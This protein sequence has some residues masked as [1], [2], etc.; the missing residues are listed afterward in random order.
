[1]I[2]GY[3]PRQFW[4]F[5]FKKGFRKGNIGILIIWI[6]SSENLNFECYKSILLVDTA[7]FWYPYAM[8][9]D[10]LYCMTF[11]IICHKMAFITD[12]IWHKVLWTIAMWVSN[13]HL[14][15]YSRFIAFKIIFDLYFVKKNPKYRNTNISLCKTKRLNNFWALS[16]CF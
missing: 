1:M 7:H 10:I 12:V 3:L 11:V 13:D 5:C 8:V 6:F 16:K 9:C 15:Q 4:P 2:Q 14:N